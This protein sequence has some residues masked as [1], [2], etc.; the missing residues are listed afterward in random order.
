MKNITKQRNNQV[1]G[2]K[3]LAMIMVMLYHFLFRYTEIYSSDYHI[4]I[5][6]LSK[7]GVIGVTIFFVV[8]GYYMSQ[9]GGGRRFWFNKILRLWPIYAMAITLCFVITKL[10]P[11]PGRT[12]NPKDYLLNLIFVNGFINIPYVDGAHWYI[13]D[14]IGCILVYSIVNKTLNK[15][16]RIIFITIFVFISIILCSFQRYNASVIS[17]ALYNLI[18]AGRIS[19]IIAGEA[20]WHYKNK[21]YG[22]F[23]YLETLAIIH[24]FLSFSV[25]YVGM[26]IISQLLLFFCINGFIKF[27]EIKPIILIGKASYPIYCFHQNIG[28]ILLYYTQQITGVYNILIGMIVCVIMLICGISIYLYIEKPIQKYNYLIK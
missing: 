18:G 23:G 24:C 20:I 10:F 19:M 9:S 21:D 6:L 26:M 27:F 8:S 12:V 1:D 7:W 22:I 4:N 28:Y 25:L 16:N 15:K 17:S 5:P 13:T 14:L 2:L 11:L 3:G